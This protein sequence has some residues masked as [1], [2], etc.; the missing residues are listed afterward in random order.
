[1]RILKPLYDNI[2]VREVAPKD[3][4]GGIIIPS[5]AQYPT[6]EGE[7]LAVGHGRLLSSGTIVPMELREGDKVRFNDFPFNEVEY[8]G[9]RV[10]H[11]KEMDVI[12]VYLEVDD[13]Q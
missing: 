13:E 9:E 8:R 4:V 6:R 1:M 11:M 7:V 10:L 3:R 12:G 2:L 5:I